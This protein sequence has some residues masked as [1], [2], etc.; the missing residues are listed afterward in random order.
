MKDRGVPRPMPV[1]RLGLSAREG[2]VWARHVDGTS[3]TDIAW[4]EGCNTSVIRETIVGIWA[5]DKAAVKQMRREAK[6]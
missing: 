5:K 1:E 2:R 4:C 3:A 6:G